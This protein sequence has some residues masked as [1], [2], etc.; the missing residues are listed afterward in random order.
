M[1]RPEDDYDLVAD[2]AGH[3]VR[4]AIESGKLRLELG[5][6]PRFEDFEQ[7]LADTDR[8]VHRPSRLVGPAQAGHRGGVRR[9]GP[10]M[11]RPLRRADA[12]PRSAGPPPRPAPRRP[13]LVRR[14]LAARQ[15]DR[16]RAAGLRAGP[17]QHRPQRRTRHDPRAPRRAVGQAGHGRLRRGVRRVGRPARGRHVRHDARRRASSPAWPCSCP[18]ASATATRPSPTTRRT[19]TWSTTTGVPTSTTS[20]ST[21]PTRPSAIAWPMPPAERVM[22]ERDRSAPPLADVSPAASA[23][24]AGARCRR[25]ARPGAACRVFP[26][27]RGVTRAELDLTDPDQLEAWPWAEHDVVLNA[28]AYTAVDLAE[29]P[30]GRR[31]AWAVN[32][33]GAGRSGPAGGDGTGSPS[34]TTPPTTCSTARATTHDEEE[35]LVSARGLRPVE[36]RR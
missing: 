24:L 36:G 12:H 26:E 28:A 21:S 15:D 35:P 1:G 14:D 6:R 32:A 13:R 10:V 11:G 30:D 8:L 7:G 27:R 9:E 20:R 29:T 18:V 3:D 2:R 31:A 25:A 16:P 33:A 34:S 4:Y 19:P 5:W 22:S 23:G 17:G